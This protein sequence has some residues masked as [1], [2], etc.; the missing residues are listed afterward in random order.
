MHLS[1]TNRE[2]ELMLA[3]TKPLAVFARER[4]RGF[5][6]SDALTN[7]DFD[8]HVARGTF[9]EQVLTIDRALPD[10]RAVTIDYFFYTLPGEEWRVPAYRLL[11]ELL[12]RGI[13]CANL[14]RLEG[15]L[16]GYSDDENDRHLAAKFPS[17]L[18]G[19]P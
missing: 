3:G 7:Q 13:W 5:G 11:V 16:L 6:K 1:H 12:S 10:G 15:T 18:M 17:H 4:V 14:E 8:T 9:V 19:S 2:L